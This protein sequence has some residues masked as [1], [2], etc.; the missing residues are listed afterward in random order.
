MAERR[1]LIVDSIE[2]FATML[3]EGLESSGPFEAIVVTSAADALNVLGRDQIDLAIVD[4]GLEDM[5]GPTLVQ[6]LRQSRPNLRIMVIPLFGQELAE[7]ELSLEVQGILPKPFF[8]GDLPKLIREALTCPFG[9]ETVPALEIPVEAPPES[10]LEPSPAPK[11]VVRREPV[12]APRDVDGILEGLFREI[13]AQA[14]LF[15]RGSE[16]IAH[17]GNVTQERA[18]ELAVLTAESLSA[19]HKIAAFLGESNDRFEQCTFEGQEF[20]VYSVNVT[21]S[22]ILSVA[23]SARTPVGM[24]RLNLRRTMD[25]LADVWYE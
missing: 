25:A 2:A 7:D 5:D 21:P 19:A 16:L 13:R 12:A 14:V 22:T 4:M 10:R 15:S 3:K 18:Q 17:A 20:S 23:L 24:V 6:S 1:I 9:D 11:V 8:I